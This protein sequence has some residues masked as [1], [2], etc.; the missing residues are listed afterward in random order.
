MVVASVHLLLIKIQ[1][2][3]EQNVFMWE[4]ILHK[5]FSAFLTQITF[6]CKLG[7]LCKLGSSAMQTSASHFCS[8]WH[9]HKVVVV[10][11]ASDPPARQGTVHILQ[12]KSTECFL[13]C[14]HLLPK[15][16]T[17]ELGTTA[18][19]FPL[20]VIFVRMGNNSLWGTHCS[21]N[22]ALQAEGTVSEQWH[23]PAGCCCSW[24][25]ADQAGLDC[26]EICPINYQRDPVSVD[27]S[28]VKTNVDLSLQSSAAAWTGWK[29]KRTSATCISV[30]NECWPLQGTR[31]HLGTPLSLV[32]E[33]KKQPSSVRNWKLCITG[34][35]VQGWLAHLAEAHRELPALSARVSWGPKPEF[36]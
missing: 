24:G 10:K 31:P 18:V 3:E 15:N 32:W 29:E 26:W 2:K 27:A 5:I 35:T 28:D 16:S 36:L 7:F 25:H 4:S 13:R 20:Y 9:Q 14:P 30:Q 19:Y 6:T 1:A 12:S 11:L 21:R 23:L 8:T 33:G 34:R 17:W 22:L